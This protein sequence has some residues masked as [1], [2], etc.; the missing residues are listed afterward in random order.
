M[1]TELYNETQ[2]ARQIVSYE[3]PD[4]DW[5]DSYSVWTHSGESLLPER[6]TPYT[7]EECELAAAAH[8]SSDNT[9]YFREY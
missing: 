5:A 8:Y 6:A 7:K 9:L 4:F 2:F 3:N 1:K